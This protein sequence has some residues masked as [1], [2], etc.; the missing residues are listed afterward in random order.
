[1]INNQLAPFSTP[2]SRESV[3]IILISDPESTMT[4]VSSL[5]GLCSFCHGPM[6]RCFLKTDGE[7]VLQSREDLLNAQH[8]CY[9]CTWIGYSLGSE[10]LKNLPQ[11]LGRR[12]MFLFDGDGWSEPDGQYER[13]VLWVIIDR[14]DGKTVDGLSL[15]L[16][17]Y[18]TNNAGTTY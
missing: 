12:F 16:Y 18:A 13:L 2:Q 6:A 9:I 8:K 5:L 15:A 17:F 14:P 11:D 7:S 3:I 4:T 10:A 1:M